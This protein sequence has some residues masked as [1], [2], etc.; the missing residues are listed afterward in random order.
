MRWI[1]SIN[2][3]SFLFIGLLI[4]LSYNPVEVQVFNAIAQIITLPLLGFTIFSLIYSIYLIGSKQNS[5]KQTK[6]LFFLSLIT[7]VMVIV[8][9]LI[10]I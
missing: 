5:S 8:I 6:F 3:V 9:T 10:Q 2:G 4:F 7:L 1:I